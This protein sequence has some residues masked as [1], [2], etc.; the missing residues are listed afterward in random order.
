VSE[1]KVAVDAPALVALPPRGTW[2]CGDVGPAGEPGGLT[3]DGA[4]CGQGVAKQGDRCGIHPRHVDDDPAAAAAYRREFSQRGVRARL[5]P[6][7]LESRADD[8]DFSS[9]AAIVT[10]CALMAGKV[11]RGEF[12]DFKGLDQQ[13][14]L[15][16]LALDSHG[17]AAL[18]QLDQ[19]EKMVRARIAGV[20]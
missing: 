14:K 12:T 17:V 3:R 9:P 1:Q 7:R 20:A 2:T 19:L 11:S 6:R 5:T 18:E 4:P 16:R 15:A 8:P 13:T 10:W